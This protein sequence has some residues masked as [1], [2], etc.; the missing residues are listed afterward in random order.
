MFIITQPLYTTDA[1][2]TGGRKG[3]V[4]T[5]DGVL[6][7]DVRMPAVGSKYTNPEQ[8][9]AAGY[10]SCFNGAIMAVAKGRN[11]EGSE[12]T[13]RVTFGKSEAGGFGLA[14]TLEVKLPNLPADE[15]L[16][17]VE[18]AHQV[19]PYSVATRGNIEVTLKV[20]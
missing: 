16:H 7:M 1:T 5:S 3:H 19:C 15:A 2:N 6:D 13:A 12:V 4:N 17:L 11:V 14:V 9:F 10:A 20:A 18:E 8:L